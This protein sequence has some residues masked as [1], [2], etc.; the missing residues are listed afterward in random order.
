MTYIVNL[1]VLELVLIFIVKDQTI[2]IEEAHD[3]CFPA[4]T[5]EEVYNY[6]EEPVLYSYFREMMRL[7]ILRF[8]DWLLLGCW[9]L[10]RL[11]HES[12]LKIVM[13]EQII[14]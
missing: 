11:R 4:R 7:Y 6:I 14:L 12:N 1:S 3:W 5:S 8:L 2:F 13:E 10:R 9:F